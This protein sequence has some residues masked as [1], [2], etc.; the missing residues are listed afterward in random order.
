MESIS[1]RDLILQKCNLPAVPVVAIKVIKLIDDP[2]SSIEDIRRSISGDQSLIASILRVANSAFYGV[3]RKIDTISEAILI[4]GLDTVKTIALAVCTKELYKNFG[5]IEQKL[6]EHSIGVSLLAG[7]LANE[8]FNIKRDEAIVAGLLHDIGKTVMNNS[9]PD[10]FFELTQMVY[11]ERV[12]YKDIEMDFF[13]FGHAD[14]GYLLAQKWEFSDTLCEVI[15][16]HHN[17]D[18]YESRQQDIYDLC[19]IVALSDAICVRLGIGYRGPMME[20]EDKVRDLRL[21]LGINE[22]RYNEL[23]DAFKKAYIE[24]RNF[25]KL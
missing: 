5:I 17:C 7:I 9:N 18:Y 24:E 10:K 12:N 2:F 8:G 1:Q 6:W 15:K 11:N 23:L 16:N 19:L 14:V 3:G 21:K 22:N 4:M 25:Y 13:G 20:M